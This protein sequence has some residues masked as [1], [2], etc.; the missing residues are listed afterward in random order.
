MHTSVQLQSTFWGDGLVLWCALLPLLG[1]NPQSVIGKILAPSVWITTELYQTWMSA[2]KGRASLY[3]AIFQFCTSRRGNQVIDYL[4]ES[5]F[6]LAKCRG[7]FYNKVEVRRTDRQK[8]SLW[9][10]RGSGETCFIAK[11]PRKRKFGCG[12]EGVIL[13]NSTY[14]REK[15]NSKQM[16]SWTV[17]DQDCW[18]RKMLTDDR[19]SFV[20][21]YLTHL[22]PSENH[23]DGKFS[24][25]SAW[26]I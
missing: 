2:S 21:N 10:N 20:Y 7:K 15:C 26:L 4:V 25:S 11:V 1:L 12:S 23:V 8:E 19:F 22:F 13:S 6:H 14:E 5:G 18:G 17:K 16:W 24:T 3:K 9:R